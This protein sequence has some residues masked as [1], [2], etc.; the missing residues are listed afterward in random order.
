ME[1]GVRKIIGLA[2]LARSGKDTVASL[3]LQH[4]KVAAY[5]LADPVK[6]GC[7]VL[8]GLTDEEAWSDTVKEDEIPL[9]RRSPRELFQLTGTDWMRTHNPEHWL[10][11]AELAIDRPAIPANHT[12]EP[13]LLDAKA[14][15]KLAAKAFFDLS[16]DQTWNN[17]FYDTNDSFWGMTPNQMFQLI[18][19]LALI[20][21]PDYY[22]QRAQRPIALPTREIPFFDKNEIIIIK[23]IRFENEAAFI[24]NHEGQIWHIVRD[25]AEK[26][27]AHTSELGISVRN[28]D[29]V[30]DNNG[31]LEQLA[32]T[33]NKQW[34]NCFGK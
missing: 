14:P 24:R 27:N 20:D 1:V 30:I 9:W 12:I 19:S 5:A 25:S 26:I 8:F 31:T 21:F 11:R 28:S 3:L 17:T 2:A 34:Q 6:I 7:Q 32:D 15:F 23:D 16:D 22:E 4:R 10:M 33:V 13:Q 29:I 18:N